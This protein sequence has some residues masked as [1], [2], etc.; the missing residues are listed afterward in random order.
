MQYFFLF[1]PVLCLNA[2]FP[3]SR[4]VQMVI[5]GTGK[6]GYLDN[7]IPRS[8]SSDLT[9]GDNSMV[10]AWLINFKVDSP[11]EIYM[12]YPTAKAIWDIV[13]LA[14]LDLEDSSQ[15]SDLHNRLR[16]L[17]QGETLILFFISSLYS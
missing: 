5:C 6:F 7:F 10:M 15:M 3:W 11:A 9:F 16:L 17:R 13:S 4:S 12:M 14:Y 2:P 8:S 1:S